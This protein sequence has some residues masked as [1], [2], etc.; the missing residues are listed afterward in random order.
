MRRGFVVGMLV[1]A[2]VARASDPLPANYRVPPVRPTA[3]DVSYTVLD[4]GYPFKWC[5]LRAP[6]GGA[7]L[8]YVAASQTCMDAMTETSLTLMV[9]LIRGLRAIPDNANTTDFCLSDSQGA[10]AITALLNPVY[11]GNFG[12]YTGVWS[13]DWSGSDYSKPFYCARKARKFLLYHPVACANEPELAPFLP[14]LDLAIANGRCVDAP[15]TLTFPD[16]IDKRV[17]ALGII[18]YDHRQPLPTAYQAELVHGTHEAHVAVSD[19]RCGVGPAPPAGSVQAA[20][21]ALEES[22]RTEAERHFFGL[23]AFR[24]D[25]DPRWSTREV[26]QWARLQD[27]DHERWM[28]AVLAGDW[29]ASRKAE[30][31]HSAD[32]L[33]MNLRDPRLLIRR[34]DCGAA[35]VGKCPAETCFDILE[36]QP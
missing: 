29:A 19:W 36:R 22:A 28:Q 27:R 30:N 35:N 21:L 23:K 18:D 34:T 13:E 26:C 7:F 4:E 15:R 20:H 17:R 16:T 24:G 6:A 11:E 32:H 10:S 25:V 2:S 8:G 1:W 3:Q 31:D 33:C 9:N 5:P 14:W 12:S